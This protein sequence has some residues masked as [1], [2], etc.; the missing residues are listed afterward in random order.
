MSS[1]IVARRGR[2]QACPLLVLLN[3]RARQYIPNATPS[4][5]HVRAFVGPAGAPITAV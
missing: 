3:D 2:G 5:Q 4:N 1:C